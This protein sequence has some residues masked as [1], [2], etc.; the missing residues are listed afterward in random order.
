MIIR[1][2]IWC[3]CDWKSPDSTF[4]ISLRRKGL[5][6]NQFGRKI[7]TCQGVFNTCEDSEMCSVSR[8]REVIG[9]IFE[10]A[11]PREKIRLGSGLPV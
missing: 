9:N 7:D 4:K 8:P 11:H 6:T 1:K 2:I 3:W 5:N 10:V